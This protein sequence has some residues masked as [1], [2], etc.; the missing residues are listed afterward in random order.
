VGRSATEL[1][2]SL[3]GAAGREAVVFAARAQRLQPRV[4]VVSGFGAYA[5]SDAMQRFLAQ[6]PRLEASLTPELMRSE[7]LE[8]FAVETGVLALL[9]RWGVRLAVVAGCH[10]SAAQ[11]ARVASGARRIA[12]VA[13]DLA[14]PPA[15]TDAPCFYDAATGEP[16][17]SGSVLP[18]AAWSRAHA[19]AAFDELA[20]ALKLQAIIVLGAPSCAEDAQDAASRESHKPRTVFWPLVEGLCTWRELHELLASLWVQGARIDWRAV[21]DGRAGGWRSVPNYPFQRLTSWFIPSY[22]RDEAAEPMSAE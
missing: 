5:R 1:A 14:G 20:V 17:A 22:E 21:D 6:A 19:E 3:C 16:L 8:R 4:G 13:R 2:A 18:S 7:Q 11:L 15:A 12:D 10:P 9:R